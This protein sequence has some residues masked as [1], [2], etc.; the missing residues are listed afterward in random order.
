MERHVGEVTSAAYSPRLKSPLAL[1]YV[2]RGHEAV[3]TKL[4]SD[5]G[6]AEVILPPL[7]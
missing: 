1:A 2:R 6:K 5:Y 4:D 7:T 3:G